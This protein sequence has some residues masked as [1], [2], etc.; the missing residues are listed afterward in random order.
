[1]VFLFKMCKY[2]KENEFYFETISIYCDITNI[3][4]KITIKVMKYISNIKYG[5][6]LKLQD[7]KI[8]KEMIGFT[9]MITKILILANMRHCPN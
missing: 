7:Y 4:Y 9:C 2:N 5:K 8:Y 1:M 3:N 6:N